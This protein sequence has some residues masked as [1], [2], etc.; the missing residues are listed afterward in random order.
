MLNWKQAWNRAATAFEKA[1]REEDGDFAALINEVPCNG[2]CDVV[3]VL[4]AV[5]KITYETRCAMLD[6]VPKRRPYY[7]F[8]WSTKADSGRRARVR[9]CRKMAE[10]KRPK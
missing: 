6:A 5:G 7:L 4:Q 8:V 1:T 10:T 3:N 2:V 9:F